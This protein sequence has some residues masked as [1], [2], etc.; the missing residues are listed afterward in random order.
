MIQLRFTDGGTMWRSQSPD[1]NVPNMDL[2]WWVQDR[3]YE[4]YFYEE[5]AAMAKTQASMRDVTRRPVRQWPE[6]ISNH[7]WV[8]RTDRYAGSIEGWFLEMKMRDQ[9]TGNFYPMP[10]CPHIWMDPTYEP[11]ELNAQEVVTRPH[12]HHNPAEAATWN[13]NG[14]P[15]PWGRLPFKNESE[16]QDPRFRGYTHLKQEI[17]VDVHGYEGAQIALVNPNDTLLFTPF[18]FTHPE[19]Y[20]VF[21]DDG[22]PL[23]TDPWLFIR[24]DSDY[25]I[26]LR[27]RWWRFTI[28]VLA[29]YAYVSLWG[30]QLN[31][32]YFVHTFFDRPTVYPYR[33]DCIHSKQ[34]QGT[35][36]WNNDFRSYDLGLDMWWE[37]TDAAAN[38]A[39]EMLDQQ[40]SWYCVVYMFLSNE[41]PD[42][43]IEC[44]PPRKGDIVCALERIDKATGSSTTVFVQQNRYLNHVFPDY[45]WGAYLF[46]WL[47]VPEPAR[48]KPGKG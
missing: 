39:R 29:H 44:W 45:Q 36:N 9:L 19:W 22:N 30:I 4:H 24:P 15:L 20:N 1:R 18:D 28:F 33:H 47:V 23:P 38:L 17:L 48:W 32:E 25:V 13:P 6:K 34:V 8:D 35:P 46:N 21:T 12:K 43:F 10:R 27:P 11:P 5:L 7:M 26:H 40:Y 16:A 42:C 37:T 41:N 31:D 3:N 14:I 2:G